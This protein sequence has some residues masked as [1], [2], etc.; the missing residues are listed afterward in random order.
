MSLHIV[1]AYYKCPNCRFMHHSIFL[2]C[3]LHLCCFLKSCFAPTSVISSEATEKAIELWTSEYKD[4]EQGEIYM[5]VKYLILDYPFFKTSLETRLEVN[6]LNIHCLE[7][8][9]HQRIN[10]HLCD[11]KKTL[12]EQ[13]TTCKH[14]WS[15]NLCPWYFCICLIICFT[16]YFCLIRP[17]AVKLNSNH[18]IIV[19]HPLSF[20]TSHRM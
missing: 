19:R 4:H 17:P 11:P 6:R 9:L 8:K 1:S 7:Y 14:E 10:V 13:C 5:K 16:L 2:R 12:H 18:F 20:T 3:G 15:M